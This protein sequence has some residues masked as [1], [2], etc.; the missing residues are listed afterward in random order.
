MLLLLTQ[1]CTWKM[2]SSHTAQTNV[3]CCC[4][5]HI[6]PSSFHLWGRIQINVYESMRLSTAA[7]HVSR[8]NWEHTGTPLFHQ[9]TFQY[10]RLITGQNSL[11]LSPVKTVAGIVSLPTLDQFNIKPLSW[12][13]VKAEQVPAGAT[14]GRRERKQRSAAPHFHHAMHIRA[15]QNRQPLRGASLSYVRQ[16][17]YFV[18]V[19]ERLLARQIGFQRFSLKIT[20]SVWCHAMLGYFYTADVMHRE[21]HGTKWMKLTWNGLI[22]L[23]PPLIFANLRWYQHTT[24]AVMKGP[25][26]NALFFSSMALYKHLGL[27]SS[28]SNDSSHPLSP[29]AMGI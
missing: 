18:W 12:Q 29:E 3:P 2:F 16:R 1:N 11:P 17:H 26:R 9:M 8:S 10:G 4:H 21:C 27:M 13:P 14:P 28:D 23:L 22:I 7:C 20:Q 25:E 6:H 5:P 19:F 24:E 15:S